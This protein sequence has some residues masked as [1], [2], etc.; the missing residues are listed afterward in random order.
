[1]KVSL[2]IAFSKVKK[3]MH[4]V[5]KIQSRFVVNHWHTF[6]A[7]VTVFVCMFVSIS[8]Q[9]FYRVRHGL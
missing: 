6:A 9:L 3:N 8:L 4:G 5:R 7:T 1:M 2:C